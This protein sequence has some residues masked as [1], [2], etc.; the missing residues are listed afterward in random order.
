MRSNAPVTIQVDG[1]V[2]KPGT[3]TLN[4]TSTVREAIQAA[5][6][7]KKGADTDSID[8]GARVQSGM[9]V[10]IAGIDEMGRMSEIIYPTPKT[11]FKSNP[12]KKETL[13]SLAPGSI[14]L[15]QASKADLMKLP[16][17]GSSIAD[18]IIQ[19]RQ[20]YGFSTI[21]DL[22]NVK[23]IGDKTM[24]QIRPYVRL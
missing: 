1:A 20:Q 3:I 8:M 6:G 5:G 16:R 14:S 19:Y 4:P 7:T 12:S 23:G 21:D 9:I 24:E 17:V 10:F 22:N 13:A 15:N 18:R 11:G 2:S